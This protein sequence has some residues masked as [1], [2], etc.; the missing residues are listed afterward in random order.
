[1]LGG[2]VFSGIVVILSTRE[3]RQFEA[4]QA[5]KL[6]FAAFLGFAVTSYLLANDAG[7]QSCSRADSLLVVAGGPFG[8]FSVLMLVALTWLVAAYS[9]ELDDVLRLLRILIYIASAFVVLLLCVSSQSF[10]SAELGS[11]GQLSLSAV[12]KIIYGVGVLAIVAGV[13][14]LM[15]R[16]FA[17]WIS[18]WRRWVF[19]LPR[20]LEHHSRSDTQLAKR[21]DRCFYA[22]MYYLAIVGLGAGV[23]IGLPLDWYQ[24]IHQPFVYFLGLAALLA[25]VPVFAL[26]AH[27]LARVDGHAT[28]R[29]Y[30]IR[31]SSPEAIVLADMLLELIRRIMG[32]RHLELSFAKYCVDISGTIC[33][34]ITMYPRK[35][36]LGVAFKAP[37]SNEIS[38]KL[39]AQGFSAAYDKRSGTYWLNLTSG[40]FAERQEIILSLIR[41]T[42]RAI[43]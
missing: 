40:D 5:L 37:I 3:K 36:G 35:A 22:A 19:F 9:D 38:A 23:V 16:K 4:A 8:T 20:S 33:T 11:H 17:W 13:V 34:Y 32:D 41:Q 2:F 43:R 27:A 1:M 30:W 10:I 6:L 14:V 21:V 25:P 7:E 26:G 39:E 12:S 24:P 18:R 28:D 42:V 15:R 29:E 31:K